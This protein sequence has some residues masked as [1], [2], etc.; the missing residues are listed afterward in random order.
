MKKKIEKEII[1]NWQNT[2][3]GANL[4]VFNKFRT[5][6]NIEI[7]TD[8]YINI[9]ATSRIIMLKLGSA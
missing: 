2:N 4:G 3:L 9:A 7:N 1:K 8:K 6:I 5:I